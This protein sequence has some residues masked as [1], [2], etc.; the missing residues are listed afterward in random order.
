MDPASP[1]TSLEEATT[2]S[3]VESGHLAERG[4]PAFPRSRGRLGTRVRSRRLRRLG[5][6]RG[7]R[8]HGPAPQSATAS[9][10][11]TRVRRSL[12]EPSGS[13]V[14]TSLPPPLNRVNAILPP[15][16]PPHRAEVGHGVPRQ[17]SQARASR[18]DPEE[19]GVDAVPDLED[20][21]GAIRR[22][23]RRAELA[24][25]AHQAV[26]VRPVGADHPDLAAGRQAP[27]VG[28]PAG[29]RTSPGCRRL[30]GGR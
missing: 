21:P 27:H 28:D 17:P 22:P 12:S 26:V 10:V 4:A 15:S 6:A 16:G 13:I 2:R 1:A 11:P 20:E 24:I 18:G 25:A 9:W 5:A 3:Y 14:Q 7:S 30:R 29:R 19:L 23:G 8:L